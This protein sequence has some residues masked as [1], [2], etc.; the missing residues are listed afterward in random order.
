MCA[1]V[2]AAERG[3]E[4]NEQIAGGDCNALD[5]LEIVTFDHDQDL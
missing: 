2:N 3:K 1:R 4:I 5:L